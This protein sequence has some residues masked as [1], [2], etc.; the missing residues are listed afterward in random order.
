MTLKNHKRLNI[1]FITEFLPWPLNSG[2]R[3]RSYNIMMDVS[4]RHQVTVIAKDYD[5]VK[6]KFAYK[7]E[8]LHIVNS[9]KQS[10]LVKK[11]KAIFAIFSKKPYISTFI[12]YDPEMAKKIQQITAEQEFDIVH[13][14]HL[15]ATIYLNNCGE[16]PTYL[17]EHNYESDLLRSIISST[18]NSIV[19][20]FLI[21]QYEKLKKY[22]TYIL[23]AV[24]YVGTVSEND[25]DTIKRIAQKSIVMVIP[26]GVDLD[27]F[28]INRSPMK[29]RIISIGSLDWLPNEEGLIWF[30]KNVW[31]II[32]TSID[33]PKFQI[34]G[35]NPSSRILKNS[36]S[37]IEIHGSVAD[38]RSY[39]IEASV[40]VV[41]L[42][43]GSGTRLKVLEAM[44]MG[45]P[46]VSTE[47][48][49][50]GIEYN[51]GINIIIANTANDFAS[52]VIRLCND[53]NYA[54]DI[55]REAKAL[56]ADKYTWSSVG[57]KLDK[58]YRKV[59]NI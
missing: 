56:V 52:F 31:P 9:R 12:H 57:I 23:N 25:A 10:N 16:L 4:K 8:K 22:E 59:L 50:E 6:D 2:G 28:T 33:K 49:A 32:L 35:R 54:N 26:N 48:G 11:I 30:I 14:D 36:N 20:Y 15:D 21:N 13:L 46:I 44:A 1:L 7:L 5:N 55:S 41:P 38:V 17:D 45:I 37:N 27:F 24:N 58:C 42:F 51:N 29:N 53:S 19:R 47:K 34:V 3:I 43:S 40:F 18:K 39:A